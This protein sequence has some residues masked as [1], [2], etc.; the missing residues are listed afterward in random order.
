M[1]S[2]T[3]GSLLYEAATL[4]LTGMLFVFAFLVLLIFAIKALAAF[5]KRYPGAEPI[6]P[7][8]RKT[9]QAKVST[10]AEG[11]DGKTLS[12]ITAAIHQH[13]NNPK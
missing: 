10:H 5:C 3:L 13:R 1:T 8:A 7:V 11:I 12:I 6:V 9:S 2:E 4:M